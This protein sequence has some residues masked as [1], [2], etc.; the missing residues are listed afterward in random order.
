MKS[1]WIP[2]VCWLAALVV[3]MSAMADGGGGDTSLEA[4]CPAFAAWEQAHH[5][6]PE[7]AHVADTATP[8]DPI[9]RKRLLAMFKADQDARNAWI[10]AGLAMDGPLAKRMQQ[11]DADH[12]VQLRKMLAAHG[13]PTPAMVGKDGVQAAFILVQHAT[14][15][16]AL[17]ASVLP[18]LAKLRAAGDVSGQD[19]AL[20]TDRVLREQGK[21]QRYGTQ[22]ISDKRTHGVM[23]LQPTE[24]LAHVDARR[25]EVGLPPLAAYVCILS[26]SYHK[27]VSMQVVKDAPAALPHKS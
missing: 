27:P 3:S 16:P 24:D 10:A 23:M 21:P 14:R 9:L 17:Q 22:F 11:V 25:A 12:L 26:A 1:T 7:K 2:V 15:D 13:F 4:A 18:Q 20:L 8:T 5:K 19:F 6:P